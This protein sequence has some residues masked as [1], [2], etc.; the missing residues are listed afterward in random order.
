LFGWLA[1][2]GGT[3]FVD[4]NCRLAAARELSQIRAAIESGLLVVLFP[5]GTSSDG[6]TV[7]PFKSSLLQ[8]AVSTGCPIAPAGI[9]YRLARGSVANEV[10][11]WRDMTLVPHLLNLL[12]KP[13]IESTIRFSSPKPRNGDRKALARALRAEVADLRL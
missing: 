5:E 4:R 11:Y 13:H 6:A 2:A 12:G 8:G 7:L 3:I 1:R 10:C 9:A